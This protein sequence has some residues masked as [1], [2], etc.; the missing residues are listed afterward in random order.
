MLAVQVILAAR[1]AM[2]ATF[3]VDK[4][5]PSALQ[6]CRDASHASTLLSASAAIKIIFGF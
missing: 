2:Q 1:S 6:S 3:S 5:A 4:A